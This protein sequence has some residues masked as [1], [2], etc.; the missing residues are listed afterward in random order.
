MHADVG[1][2]A[3]VI[4]VVKVIGAGIVGDVEVGPAVIVET[5]SD[6][7]ETVVG[8]RVVH[9][10]FL[11][12]FIACTV[13]PVVIEQIGL[14]NHAPGTALHHDDLCEFAGAE[15]SDVGQIHVNVPRDENIDEAVLIV[16]RPGS[17]ASLSR[18]R[19]RPLCP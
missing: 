5:A 14:A 6:H 15:C 11:R 8:V 10:R 9:A 17:A 3:V 7:T 1:E 4:V 12:D 13:A 19:G 2:R 16:I 18:F